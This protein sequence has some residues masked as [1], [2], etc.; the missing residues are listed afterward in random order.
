M[1][2]LNYDKKHASISNQSSTNQI[3][4][5][6]L[7][8][9]KQKTITFALVGTLTFASLAGGISNMPSMAETTDINQSSGIVDTN[10][11]TS[12]IYFA[13]TQNHWAKDYINSLK[14]QGITSG[15]GD[16]TFKPDN[17]INRLEYIIL[18]LKAMGQTVRPTENGEFWGQPY[19]E[20]AIDL[21][22]VEGTSQVP[23]NYEV[24]ISR[25]EMASIIMRA[26][27][28]VDSDS[29]HE[30]GNTNDSQDNDLEDGSFV[31]ADLMTLAQSKISDLV[32]TSKVYQDEVTECYA[33]NFISGY[34]DGSFKPLGNASRA[35]A[36]VVISKLLDDSLRTPLVVEGTDGENPIDGET[37][38]DASNPTDPANPSDKADD[39]DKTDDTALYDDEGEKIR[40]TN[41]PS[42]ADLYPYILERI[43]NMVYEAPSY[44]LGQAKVLPKDYQNYLNSLDDIYEG[45]LKYYEDLVMTNVSHRLNVDYRTIDNTWA[46][47]LYKTYDPNGVKPNWLQECYDYVQ[48]V[49]DHKIIIKA[50]N[51]IT[52]KSLAFKSGFTYLRTY[53]NY[54]IIQYENVP[55]DQK[56]LIVEG[57]RQDPYNKWVTTRN[58]EGVVDF[59][60]SSLV[61]GN[62]MTPQMVG[63]NPTGAYL[64][65]IQTIPDFTLDE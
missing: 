35:E 33:L 51:I 58:Y 43:P 56:Y 28:Y 13:D 52:D 53:V 20:K 38:G 41:L 26:Y 47:E 44:Y 14:E 1:N 61:G 22:L 27:K 24:N 18:T 29:N 48:F 34:G 65:Q 6:N 21:G 23:S 60:L 54:D 10:S 50:N 37:D 49:K 16:N 40:T 19:I 2:N 45:E 15:Y 46:E 57:T 5:S 36:S 9:I 4:K 64:L 63:V 55:E 59:R 62:Y 31:D 32:N 42:N 12:N 25:Q 30:T 17:T 3:A 39:I 8:T 7:H 11:S